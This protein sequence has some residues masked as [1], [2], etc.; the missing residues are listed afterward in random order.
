MV[1]TIDRHARGKWLL[2]AHR[3]LG[4]QEAVK[5]DFVTLLVYKKALTSL[6][7]LGGGKVIVVTSGTKVIIGSTE[8]ADDSA[9]KDIAYLWRE[10]ECSEWIT[11][12]DV[13]ID[14]LEEPTAES[15]K[16]PSD[17]NGLNIVVGGFKGAIFIYEDILR[18]LKTMEDPVHKSINH[19]VNPRRLHWHRN[20]VAAVKWS[21]DGKF[22]QRPWEIAS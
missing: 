17:A 22:A 1:Y 13:Q 10:I 12:I 3:L 7:V 18:R 16:P 9:L 2:T 15:E 8:A 14:H 4:G 11:S 19:Q 20:S 21:T 5:A 6:K